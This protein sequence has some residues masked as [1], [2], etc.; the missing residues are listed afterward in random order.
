VGRMSRLV[1]YDGY[2]SLDSGEV[3]LECSCGYR[4][5]EVYG[6]VAFCG[7]CRAEVGFLNQDLEDALNAYL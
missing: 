7:N 5:A 4:V 1:K 3:E 6:K 2:D